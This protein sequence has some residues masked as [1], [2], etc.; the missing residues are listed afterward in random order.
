MYTLIVTTVYQAHG[1]ELQKVLTAMAE[2]RDIDG[3]YVTQTGSCH[4]EFGS[5]ERA[6]EIER[7]LKLK[8]SMRCYCEIRL[9]TDV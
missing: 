5:K 4:I 9:S 7:I 6:E 1:E 3:F 8:G 2:N